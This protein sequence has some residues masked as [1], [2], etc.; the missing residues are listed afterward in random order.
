LR[1][2]GLP[3]R[4][5]IYTIAQLKLALGELK[6]GYGIQGSDPGVGGESMDCHAAPHLAK[7]GAKE[8]GE[9]NA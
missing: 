8:R 3:I 5:D 6:M 7:T 9:D 1:A 4:K 2:L